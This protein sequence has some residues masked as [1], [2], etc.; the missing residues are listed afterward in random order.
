MSGYLAA[1]SSNKEFVGR[2]VEAMER[3]GLEAKAAAIERGYNDFHPD[4]TITVQAASAWLRGVHLPDDEHMEGL[5]MWLR[6]DVRALRGKSRFQV[7]EPDSHSLPP[8]GK[9]D[10]AT[11]RAFAA[12]P[13]PH[14][15][16]VREVI[17]ALSGAATPDKS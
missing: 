9:Q 17:L 1:M 11:I 13:V 12:L 7:N 16:L 5:A 4:T 10:A 2:L 15:K 8:M 3:Q 6:I 14:R